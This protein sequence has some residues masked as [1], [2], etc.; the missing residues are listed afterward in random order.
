MDD[1]IAGWLLTGRRRWA[2]WIDAKALELSFAAAFHE[3]ASA[4]LA[5]I[6]LVADF[7]ALKPHELLLIEQATAGQGGAFVEH[8][9][10]AD[11]VP[12]T[13]LAADRRAVL[14]SAMR[15]QSGGLVQ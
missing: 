15:Y 2:A 11:Q 5:V 3:N 4:S 12:F 13:H 8:L 10:D 1:L 7:P 14:R 9:L 6:R